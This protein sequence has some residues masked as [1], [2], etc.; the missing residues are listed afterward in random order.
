M[1]KL[2]NPDLL[3]FLACPDCAGAL[4][5]S[6]DALQCVSCAHQFEIRTGIPLLYSKDTDF[7]HM[8]EEENLA[9][10]MV[11]P[12]LNAKERFSA[13]QWALSKDEF[14]SI[15][16]RSAQRGGQSFINLG[17]GYDERFQRIQEQGNT[18][19]NFDMIYDMLHG[20]QTK[21]S[22]KS[23]VGGDINHL[24]FKKGSFDF[25]ISIDLIHHESNDL[26]RL[27]QSFRDLLKPG[28]TLFLED[29]NAWGLFQMW[30]SVLLPKPLYR[31]LRSAYHRIKRSEHRPAD[32][33]FPTS[34][35]RVKSILQALGFRDIQFYPHTAYPAI[36]GS[37]YRIYRLLSSRSEYLRKYSNFHYM[38]SATRA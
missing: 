19:V 12:R 3:R 8:R 18:F 27:L 22:A 31:Q 2:N 37:N 9:K 35:W 36:G 21:A 17:C 5:D 34:V 29:P 33:E 32:Y 15:V 25:A 26:P 11:A 14:W 30:K 24:P 10:M 28:G 6:G 4:R 23:C 13:E 38:L 20:L 1:S 7:E 16:D